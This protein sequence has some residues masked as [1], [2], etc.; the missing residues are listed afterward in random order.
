MWGFSLEKS[1]QLAARSIENNFSEDGRLLYSK[2]RPIHD[3]NP[4]NIFR[5]RKGHMYSSYKRNFVLSRSLTPAPGRSSTPPPPSS[6]SRATASKSPYEDP[7]KTRS[8]TP[9]PKEKCF[10]LQKEHPSTKDAARNFRP[11]EQDEKLSLVHLLRKVRKASPLDSSPKSLSDYL[12]EAIFQQQKKAA[13]QKNGEGVNY[14]SMII[15]DSELR[16]LMIQI[17]GELALLKMKDE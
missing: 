16:G 15:N 1:E 5:D 12:R 10:S 7:K 8:R 13:D 9:G 2:P 11:S 14:F 6:S 4:Q 17:L 3:P